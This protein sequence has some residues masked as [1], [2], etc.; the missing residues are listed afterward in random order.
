MVPNAMV[1]IR[2]FESIGHL[3]P[4][5]RPHRHH[6]PRHCDHHKDHCHRDRRHHHHYH[7]MV[8]TTMNTKLIRVDVNIIAIIAL[9][10]A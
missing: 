9:T 8:T 5:S 3:R 1:L 2:R 6:R 10:S 4:R 7:R